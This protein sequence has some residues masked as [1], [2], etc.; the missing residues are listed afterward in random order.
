[1]IALQINN[2]NQAQRDKKFETTMLNE[3]KSSLESDQLL[4]EVLRR[5]IQNKQNSMQELLEMTVSSKEYQDSVLLK[6]YNGMNWPLTFYYNKGG[7]EA[8]KSVGIDRISNDSLRKI[9]IETYEVDLPRA[10]KIIS[11]RSEEMTSN[12]YKLSLHNALWKRIRIKMPDNS[13]Q[14]VSQ[15]LDGKNF[16]NQ[17]ELLDR[18]KL[19]QDVVNLYNFWLRDVQRSVERCLEVVNKELDN[20]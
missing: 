6:L 4:M 19:E 8:I 17:T 16:L 10:E 14:L 13:Y 9:I 7:Y 12:D 11:L 20:D 18:M 5:F 2:W 15:P 1:M 3:I